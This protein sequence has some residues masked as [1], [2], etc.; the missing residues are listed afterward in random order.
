MRWSAGRRQRSP[1]W[2][3]LPRRTHQASRGALRE[4]GPG[5]AGLQ[6]ARFRRS[7][8]SLGQGMQLGNPY[9]QERD[10]QHYN[11]RSYHVPQACPGIRIMKSHEARLDPLPTTA[12]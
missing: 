11:H 12:C 2:R 10:E 9:H 7:L 1:T 3:L 8:A 4:A 6:R 5:V